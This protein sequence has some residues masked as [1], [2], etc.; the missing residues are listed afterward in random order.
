MNNKDIKKNNLTFKQFCNAY[1]IYN[2]DRFLRLWLLKKTKFEDI[3]KFIFNNI[4]K[5]DLNISSKFTSNNDL[6]I[7]TWFNS[8]FKNK[9]MI[10]NSV[11]L[12]ILIE[13]SYNDED[14]E[15]ELFNLFLTQLPSI[16]QMKK[17]IDKNF[18]HEREY[19][20]QYND[21]NYEA[22]VIEEDKV[23]NMAISIYINVNKNLNKYSDLCLSNIKKDGF[24]VMDYLT[25]PDELKKN[26]LTYKELCLILTSWQYIQSIHLL[27]YK[28]KD[29]NLK[30]ESLELDLQNKDKM[31]NNALN[32]NKELNNN[33]INQVSINN[34]LKEQLKIKESESIINE[35]NNKI[36]NITNELE[37][38]KNENKKLKRE[39]N[40][41][42]NELLENQSHIEYLEQIIELSKE[43]EISD[44]IDIGVS[45][46][47]TFQSKRIV[48]FG[49]C[50]NWQ[51]N[52][53][54]KLC[55]LG[56]NYLVVDL[57]KVEITILND[58][59]ILFNLHSIS[60]AYYYRVM[61]NLKYFKNKLCRVHCFGVNN[62]LNI[63]SKYS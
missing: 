46:K 56:I 22:I 41:L 24:N 39:S 19:N 61:N 23:F 53:S 12:F 35:Q 13:Q 52:I 32:K 34:K 15:K 3:E 54:K 28:Y 47:E 38:L 44:D 17:L 14:L 33:L 8:L 18:K 6:Y 1:G 9:N 26:S 40:E 48:I 16:K 57:N 10:L 11:A 30:V 59:F 49:G 50:E 51:R 20:K 63:L 21:D 58:D 60:H 25:F 45:L 27:E 2:D 37:L 42:S 31:L 29:I 36:K 43:P 5:L 55:E 4:L 62:T 7:L